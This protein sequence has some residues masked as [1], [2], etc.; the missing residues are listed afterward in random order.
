MSS[1]KIK[2][3]FI[4][5]MLLLRTERVP[6]N[7]ALSF[8]V[9]FDGFRAEAI[10]SSGRVQLRSRNNKDFNPKY[11]AIVQ[12]LAAMPD[13]TVIDGEIVALD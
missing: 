6:E 11:P 5:P 9:K 12:A 4:E 1:G 7:N 10:K 8:E 2:A 13:E 3:R